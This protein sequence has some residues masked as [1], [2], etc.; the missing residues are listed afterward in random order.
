MRNLAS[1]GAR[2]N[3]V[4]I[5]FLAITDEYHVC[6]LP[7]G[8]RAENLPDKA[9]PGA[10]GSSS[11]AG[12]GAHLVSARERCRPGAL[13]ACNGFVKRCEDVSSLVLAVGLH[14]DRMLGH[15]S[16]SC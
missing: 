15:W 13:N 14:A 8:S 10:R 2:D 9:A 3:T 1:G 16:C 4:T 12:L 7:I 5:A 11:T 6:P